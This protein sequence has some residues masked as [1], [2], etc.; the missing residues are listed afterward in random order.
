MSTRTD[1]TY[2]PTCPQGKYT[3]SAERNGKVEHR[4]IEISATDH[5]RVVFEWQS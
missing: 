4:Q 2:W 3:I 5:R 1:R